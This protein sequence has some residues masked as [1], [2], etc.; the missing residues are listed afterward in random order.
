MVL[1]ILINE[2]VA[3]GINRIHDLIVYPRLLRTCIFPA[4]NKAR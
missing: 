1:E 3:T 4:R 2:A